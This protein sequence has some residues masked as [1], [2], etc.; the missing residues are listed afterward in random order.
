MLALPW[1]VDNTALDLEG[2]EL[3]FPL[4]L[5]GVLML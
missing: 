5:S 4:P 2:S 3:S 1:A